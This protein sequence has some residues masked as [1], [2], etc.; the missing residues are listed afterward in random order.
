MKALVYEGPWTMPVRDIP[1]PE[2]KEGEV[3]IRVKI[4]GIC[5]SDIHGFTGASGRKIPPM[6]MG[7]EF[8][9]TVVSVGAGV[10]RVTPGA[11]VSVL[12]YSACGECE[13]CKA[14]FP[15]ICPNRQNLGVLDVDGAFTQYICVDEKLCYILP[16]SVSFE[17]GAILEPMAVAHHAVQAAKPLEGKTVLLVG[18]GT[19]GQLILKLLVLEKPAAVVVSDISESNLALAEKNG[20][21]VI[22]NTNKQD[23][24]KVLAAAGLASGVDVAIEAVGATPTVQQTVDFVK[25]RGRIVWVGNADKM[26]TVNMQSIVTRELHLRGSYAFTDEDFRACL[27]LLASHAVDPFDLITDTIGFGDVTPMM[28]AMAKHET[29]QIKVLAEIEDSIQKF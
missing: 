25:N 10:K 19:I 12:P 16:E 23:A 11:R 14:G 24:G 13:L 26:V 6:I 20:A 4:C 1:E 21:T 9:G 29:R 17:A 22:L 28:T 18:A 2:P 15:N 8:S 27:D 7:H 3:K 5:G